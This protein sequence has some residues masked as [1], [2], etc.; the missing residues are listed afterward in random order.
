MLSQP[1]VLDGAWFVAFSCSIPSLRRSVLCQRSALLLASV[2]SVPVRVMAI[3]IV[4]CGVASA[5]FS[6]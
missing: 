4:G 6:R 1:R 2:Q 5:S 3:Y